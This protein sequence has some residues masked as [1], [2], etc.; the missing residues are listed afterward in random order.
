MLVAKDFLFGLSAYVLQAALSL[1]RTPKNDVAAL[2]TYYADNRI[3]LPPE[4][5]QQLARH[6]PGGD[7]AVTGSLSGAIGLLTGRFSLMNR[8]WLLD[9]KQALE[10]YGR[11]MSPGYSSSVAERGELR[12]RLSYADGDLWK[13]FGRRRR[14]ELSLVDHL[15]SAEFLPHKSLREIVGDRWPLG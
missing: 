10:E 5:V 12:L 11:V 4:I 9:L 15:N 6:L 7:C 3:P 1:D 2:A 8:N 13:K 14:R